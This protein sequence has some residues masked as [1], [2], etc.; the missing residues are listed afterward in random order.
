MVKL[1]EVVYVGPADY[2]IRHKGK[3]PLL[4][5]TF[6]D[7]TEIVIRKRQS[8]C[9]KQ[10][11]LLHEV[12]HAIVWESGYRQIAELSTDTEENLVRILTP[13]ILA[14]I[15]DNPDAMAFLLDKGTRE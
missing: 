10:N 6:P 15:Q 14:F 12:I 1:P 8:F 2:L 5:E 9:S 13:W 11:T 7:D 3:Y 4:G